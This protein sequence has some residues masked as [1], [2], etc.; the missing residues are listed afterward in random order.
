MG[1][2]RG[3]MLC[4][5][6]QW[7]TETQRSQGLTPPS[8]C[9]VGADI[10]SGLIQT[11]NGASATLENAAR[12]GIADNTE[13]HAMSITDMTFP[14]K[15]FD[16][17]TINQCLTYLKDSDAHPLHRYWMKFLRP[18]GSLY[19]YDAA[20]PLFKYFL[21][22]KK[23]ASPITDRCMS[24]YTLPFPF[25]FPA[26][27]YVRITR[28]LESSSDD[29]PVPKM[30]YALPDESVSRCNAKGKAVG[31]MILGLLSTAVIVLGLGIAPPM[32]TGLFG[33]QSLF[34]K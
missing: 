4:R 14:E 24:K 29:S 16:I 33:L 12:V 31:G 3:M 19:V 2:G 30:S 1:C 15:S 7:L 5:V 23:G 26:A 13:V 32:A 8:P 34:S 6:G 9:V 10:F 27:H 17:I 18:G 11:G 25:V 21:L 28:P 22:G 20:M